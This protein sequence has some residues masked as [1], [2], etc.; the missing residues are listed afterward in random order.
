M[1]KRT[2]I[3]MIKSIA[4]PAVL[5]AAV[6]TLATTFAA[7]PVKVRSKNEQERIL[8]R[9]LSRHLAFPL[10]E[11][12]DMTGDVFISFVINTE[13]RINVLECTSKNERLK[14]Y[15]IRKLAR[16]DIGENPTGIWKT[17]HM[18]I[19]FHPERT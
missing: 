18:K 7:E 4:R 17:T 5:L 14:D 9:A 1:D 12:G 15:V 13:G 11:K 10:A 2:I 19:S 8:D 3:T 6:L 16:V